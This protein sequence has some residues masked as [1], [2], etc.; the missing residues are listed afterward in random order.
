MKETLTIILI[1][2]LWVLAH[3][4]VR[5]I[6]DIKQWDMICKEVVK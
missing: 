4:W 5:F 6:I 1:F 3:I 2:I